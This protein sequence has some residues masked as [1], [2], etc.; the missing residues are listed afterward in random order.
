MPTM[1]S[2]NKATNDLTDYL[3]LGI[4]ALFP[5]PLSFR[6]L[7]QFLEMLVGLVNQG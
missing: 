1:S 4:Q 7:Q 3:I 2:L 6:E 5:S